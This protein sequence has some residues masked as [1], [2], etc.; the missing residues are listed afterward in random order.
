MKMQFVNETILALTL[1][2]FM[3]GCGKDVPGPD[4]SSTAMQVSGEGETPDQLFKPL[5][6]PEF[7]RVLTGV[8]RTVPAEAISISEIRGGAVTE[9]EV[10]FQDA[11]IYDP[12]GI[13]VSASD[14]LSRCSGSRVRFYEGGRFLGYPEGFWDGESPVATNRKFGFYPIF[15]FLDPHRKGRTFEPGSI[16]GDPPGFGPK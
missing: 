3:S 11:V 9:M 16:L 10:S 1:F 2:L 8:V 14:F 12:G 13:Q 6:T 7:G 15:V 5:A 4:L